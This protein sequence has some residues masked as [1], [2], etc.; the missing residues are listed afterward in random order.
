MKRRIA[1][2]ALLVATAAWGILI[3]STPHL[4]RA[5]SRI[6]RITAAGAYVL[7]SAVCHQRA[8]RSFQVAGIQLP[9]C[10]RCVGLYVAAPFG[11]LLSAAGWTRGV[12]PIAVKR[13]LAAAA[14]PTA[15]TVLLEWVAL[16]QPSGPVRGLAAVP[17]GAAVAWV[18]GAT[19]RA[20]LR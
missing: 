14:V 19:L 6:S 15:A 2:I 5:E 18:V 12:K 7:G 20:D 9:V 8:D 13:G 10:A 17:L 3:L 16:W 4:A 1:M 11:L